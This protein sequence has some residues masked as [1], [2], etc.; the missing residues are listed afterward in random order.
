MAI[1][2]DM[3]TGEVTQE[4]PAPRTEVGERH[5]P[6]PVPDHD[7]GLDLQVP[8]AELPA[9]LPETLID[10]DIETFIRRMER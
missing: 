8:T 3:V 7:A 10:I 1:V 5:S 4:S 9:E 6:F 2:I